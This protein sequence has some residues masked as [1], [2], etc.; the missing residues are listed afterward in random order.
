MN[1]AGPL[2]IS[3]RMTTRRQMIAGAGMAIGGLAL[4]SASA[5]TG[6]DTGLS[7]TA[8]AIHQEPVFQATRSRVYQALT[9]ANQFEQV[10]A[11]SAA[12]KSMGG[13]ANPIEL[14]PEPGSAF[15]LF[16]G[17]IVG[18]QI[19]LVPDRLVV[20][21]WRE[22]SWKP[23]EYSI[24]KFDLVDQGSGTR[25]IFDQRGFPAG[26]GEH[27]AIGWKENYWEPLTKYLAQ[28]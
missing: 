17:H 21:A 2:S 28:K 9:D 16:E 13:R 15:A 11:L 23:G 5:W 8:E 4:G 7:R 22:V 18:R 14:R 26:A 20:Q 10:V 25:I 19:E 1:D 27:L 24:V 3:L 6:D 12:I